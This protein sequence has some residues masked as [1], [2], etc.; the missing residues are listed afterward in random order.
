MTRKHMTPEAFTKARQMLDLKPVQFSRVLGLTYQAVCDNQA[1]RRQI[2]GQTI[3]M[4]E[5]LLWIKKHNR[6]LYARL[7]EQFLVGKQ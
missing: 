1:G 6:Q 4:I 2:T 3:Q 5:V 7:I